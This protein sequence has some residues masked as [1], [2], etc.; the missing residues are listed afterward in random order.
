MQIKSKSGRSFELPTEDEEKAIN[1]GISSDK[2]TFELSNEDFSKLRPVGRPV[3]EIKKDRITIR[4]SPE[5]TEFFRATG[6]G[7]QTRMDKILLEYVAT[8]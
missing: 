6:K 2:D 7:W 3:A 5:V 1:V 4:L 8:H